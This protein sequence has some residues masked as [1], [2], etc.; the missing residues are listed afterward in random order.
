MKVTLSALITNASPTVNC[1]LVA[2][3][4]EKVFG[5]VVLAEVLYFAVNE[6]KVPWKDLPGK[7]VTE[8]AAISITVLDEGSTV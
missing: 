7:S 4:L 2:D 5:E 3:R 1:K 6:E 8:V